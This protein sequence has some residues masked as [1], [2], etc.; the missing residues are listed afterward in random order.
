[1]RTDKDKTKRDTFNTRTDTG[2]FENEDN[3]QNMDSDNIRTDFPEVLK[4][5]SFFINAEVSDLPLVDYL[6]SSNN[7]EDEEIVQE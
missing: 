5:I 1:M 6:T 4:A 3:T 2:N 7:L